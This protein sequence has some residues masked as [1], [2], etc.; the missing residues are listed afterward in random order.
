MSKNTRNVALT[1]WLNVSGSEAVDLVEKKSA[2]N[3]TLAFAIAT[4][5]YLR[6]EYSY[7]YADISN[8]ISHLPKYSTPSANLPLD[9]Q[10]PK[11]SVPIVEEPKTV[12]KTFKRMAYQVNTPTN[13]PLELVLYLQSYV[14]WHVA[15]NGTASVPFIISLNGGNFM[16]TY[17]IATA[18]RTEPTSQDHNDNDNDTKC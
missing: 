8:L 4:K 3:L 6:E 18:E 12:K 5:H 14:I 7:Q 11:T 13:I 1:I 15:K 16:H 9:A 17:F 10:A 2:I